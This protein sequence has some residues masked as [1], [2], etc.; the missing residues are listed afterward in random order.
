MREY[1]NL[2]QYFMGPDSDSCHFWCGKT[3]VFSVEQKMR[4]VSVLRNMYKCIYGWKTDGAYM[5]W[6]KPKIFY[7]EI[8]WKLE[9]YKYFDIRFIFIFITYYDSHVVHRP[10][11]LKGQ[12]ARTTP[13]Q[14]LALI[15]ST[16][17]KTTLRLV[18][19]LTIAWYFFHIRK[20][21]SKAQCI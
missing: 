14:C 2:F 21:P 4:I 17:M 18:T 20:L 3:L 8:C 5:K 12:S 1:G 16:K 11:E 10:I 7:E 13:V 19:R 15:F 9:R 6:E